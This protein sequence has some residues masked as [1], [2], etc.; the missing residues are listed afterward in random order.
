MADQLAESRRYK[1]KQQAGIRDPG[2]GTGVIFTFV[3]SGRGVTLWRVWAFP[4]GRANPP[5]CRRVS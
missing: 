1:Q 5:L 3:C 2:E 4:L